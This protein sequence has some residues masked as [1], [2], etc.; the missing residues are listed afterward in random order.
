MHTCP[1]HHPTCLDL[2][3]ARP[4]ELGLYRVELA[5]DTPRVP[6]EPLSRIGVRIADIHGHPAGNAELKVTGGMPQRGLRLPGSPVVRR[7]GGGRYSIENPGLDTPG[8]WL[9]RLTI[10]AAAGIDTVTF[11]LIL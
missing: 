7:C 4:S 6:V 11:N 9:I 10:S 1:S 5:P 3:L 8:W 2:A